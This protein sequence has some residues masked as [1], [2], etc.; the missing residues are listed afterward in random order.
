MKE[1]NKHK[2]KLPVVISFTQ[3]QA[4]S[5]DLAASQ[6]FTGSFIVAANCGTIS[7]GLHKQHKLMN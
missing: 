6:W 4:A 7:A 1:A 2:I 3:G 5:Q